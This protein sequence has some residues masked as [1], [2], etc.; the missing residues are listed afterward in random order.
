VLQKTKDLKIDFDKIQTTD[1]VIFS[2]PCNPTSLAETREDI[3][4]VIKKFP[5]TLFIADEAYMEF[6]GSEKYSVLDLTGTLP[7][8]I[9]LKT[10]S[11]ALGAAAIRLGVAAASAEVTKKLRAV[12]SPYNVNSV[13]QILGEYIIDNFNPANVQA[14]IKSREFLQA[15]L[16]KL[17]LFDKIYKSETNFV[18]AETARSKE[19]YDKL[20]QQG[21][22]VREFGGAVRLTAGNEQENKTLL[23]KLSD[24][25]Q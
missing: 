11:K 9:V 4:R 19:I 25:K 22:A 23:E 10:F 17:K 18:F 13:T 16:E 3:V 6:C 7:N 1:A 20:L 8:L 14:V 21:I 12:K 15:E 24:L 5:D 2:N